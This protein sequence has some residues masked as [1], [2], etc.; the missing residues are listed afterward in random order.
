MSMYRRAENVPPVRISG[1][2]KRHRGFLNDV[3]LATVD[4]MPVRQPRPKQPVEVCYAD[5]FAPAAEELAT[6]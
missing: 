6:A 5:F 4:A 1:Y 2:P 3:R